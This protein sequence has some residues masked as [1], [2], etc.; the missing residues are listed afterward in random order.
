MKKISFLSLLALTAMFSC[1]KPVTIDLLENEDL[2]NWSFFLP[3][4]VNA[5]DVFFMEEGILNV[6]GVPTGYMRTKEV[7]HSYELSLEWRWIA[8]PGN[9]GVLLHTTGEDLQW[10]NCIEAQLWSGKAGDFVLIGEGAGFTL[11]D[12]ARLVTSE[13]NR[14]KVFPKIEDSSEK[15][16]GEWNT[17]K[18]VVDK[19]NISLSV[20]DVLQNTCSAATKTWGNISLQ[21]E[22]APMQFRNILITLK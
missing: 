8:E 1:N 21:S 9:S 5:S 6:S 13:E 3:D 14:Y 11:N 7:F 16:A 4:T 15:A 2:S 20:N 17:Y 10:P 19:D 22:G 18:I 12:T